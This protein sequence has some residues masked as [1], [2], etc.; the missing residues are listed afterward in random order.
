MLNEKRPTIL[1]SR[2]M[3]WI[4]QASKLQQ[5]AI[6]DLR[7]GTW[8]WG[9]I[10]TRG[11]G[12]IWSGGLQHTGNSRPTNTFLKVS[13]TVSESHYQDAFSHVCTID[14]G[15]ESDRG[16]RVAIKPVD[17]GTTKKIVDLGG[18]TRT[19]PTRQT[20]KSVNCDHL[21]ADTDV[22]LD[23]RRSEQGRR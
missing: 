8:T 4:S 3:I 19:V 10:R 1:E 15:R 11:L 22:R 20:V 7:S 12:H 17:D 5:V 2:F 18:A 16:S 13:S 9:F 23:N 6:R 21:A 14:W